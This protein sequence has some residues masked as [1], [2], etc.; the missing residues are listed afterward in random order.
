MRRFSLENSIK[1]QMFDSCEAHMVQRE[2]VKKY[3]LMTMGYELAGILGFD[4][5]GVQE[6]VL[7][8]DV[9]KARVLM[10]DLTDYHK[11]ICLE[12]RS[13][14]NPKQ[15]AALLDKVKA[16]PET[17]AEDK[18]LVA[19]VRAY[20]KHLTE[21]YTEPSDTYINE[22]QLRKIKGEWVSKMVQD[23]EA[24]IKMRKDIKYV[25][26]SVQIFMNSVLYAVGLFLEKIEKE[27]NLYKLRLVNVEH[28]KAIGAILNG[29]RAEI[30]DE[31]K[32][33]GIR[34]RVSSQ[35]TVEEY[36]DRCVGV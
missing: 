30:L 29:D 25:I 23:H 8:L 27:D 16:V 24:K 22:Y 35:D 18:K 12:K 15:V 31:E 9:D 10:G 21:R 2:V 3:K 26:R 34:R 32:F 33:G 6:Y 20:I 13:A 5:D 19:K 28:Y 36:V 1:N 14:F 4:T 11:H 17:T 7:V